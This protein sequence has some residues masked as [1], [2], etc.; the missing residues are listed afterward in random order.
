MMR[1]HPCACGCGGLTTS[2]RFIHGHNGRGIPRSPVEGSPGPNPSG[3]CMCGCGQTTPLAKTTD[4]RSGNVK[5]TPIRF[6]HGHAGRGARAHNWSGGRT[7]RRGYVY[8]LRPD[9]PDADRHGYVCEHV[10][11]AEKA[12]GKSLPA[13]VEVHHV[14][15]RRADNRN[16]N[17]VVC[18][19]HAYHVLLHIRT[20]ALKACGNANWRQCKYCKVWDDPANLTNVGHYRAAR[21]P[22]CHTRSERER[23]L[24]KSLEAQEGRDG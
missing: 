11:K 17:L 10:L 3:R 14:N 7:I 22:A 2:P 21:H 8:V 6:V 4:M 20:R 19:D 5:G 12:L 9:H 1:E 15:E 23:R 16:V 13:G 18:Q 24:A